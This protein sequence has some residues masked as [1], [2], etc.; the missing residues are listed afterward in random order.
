MASYSVLWRYGGAVGLEHLWLEID[1]GVH[2][3]G[4]VIGEFDKTAVRIRYRLQCDGDWRVRELAIETLDREGRKV[5]LRADGAG[6]WIDEH[7]RPLTQ[8][9]TCLDVDIMVTPFTN[10]LPIRRLQLRP[11]DSRE[12]EVV[13]VAVPS[14]ELT[15][16]RQRY[17]CLE[18]NT[19]GG[20]Y[21]YESLAT[22]FRADLTVDANGLVL[23]YPGLFSRV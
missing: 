6:N 22:G 3:D 7:G 11:S 23:D 10:T 1:A 16:A 19:A 14:L 8:F 13:Y 9:A 17:T 18:R 4:V 21:Q 20:R 5:Q 2:A 15:R 12:I